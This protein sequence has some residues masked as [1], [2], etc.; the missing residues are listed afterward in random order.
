MSAHFPKG[1]TTLRQACIFQGPGPEPVLLAISW[2]LGWRKIS[3]NL[4]GNDNILVGP[5]ADVGVSPFFVCAY[6]IPVCSKRASFQPKVAL[7]VTSARFWF[8][9]WCDC[10]KWKQSLGREDSAVCHCGERAECP[11]N[12]VRF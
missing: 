7:I 6:S 9:H 1:E 10:N 4:I 8:E 11:D 3:G 2:I 12:I 5:G